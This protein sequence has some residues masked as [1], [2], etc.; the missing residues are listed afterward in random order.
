[1]DTEQG[2]VFRSI[3][4]CS[5]RMDANKAA[6]ARTVHTTGR[7]MLDSKAEMLQSADFA[8]GQPK[9]KVKTNA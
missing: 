4:V 9:R 8:V 5:T 2:A 7:S 1:M 3:N 6:K